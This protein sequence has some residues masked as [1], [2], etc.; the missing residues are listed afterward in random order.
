MICSSIISN[1]R[2]LN[3]GFPQPDP[4]YLEDYE[5]RKAAGRLPNMKGRGFQPGDA[6]KRTE[7]ENIY[8]THADIQDLRKSYMVLPPGD[9]Q[10]ED[11]RTALLNA[12]QQA[13]GGK[14]DLFAQAVSAMEEEE[15]YAR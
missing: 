6:P 8:F 5:A 12:I 11:V 9:P 4:D 13:V 14:E 7:G 2:F 3:E 1:T 10:E 15:R